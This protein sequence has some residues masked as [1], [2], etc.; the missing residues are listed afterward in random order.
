MSPTTFSAYLQS[1]LYGFKAFKIEES[2]KQIAKEVEKLARHLR[3]YDEHFKKVGK[4][5]GATVNHYDAAQKNFG[6]IEKDVF[7]ITDGRAEIQFEPLEI[8][9]PTTEA[10]K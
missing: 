3:A 9:G 1:V 7:K 8:S 2:A 10:I 4:S 5:L 6:M